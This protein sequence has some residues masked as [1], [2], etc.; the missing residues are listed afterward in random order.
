MQC[1]LGRC[2]YL[3]Q[4]PVHS[5]DR[6][7]TGQVISHLIENVAATSQF[8]TCRKMYLQNGDKCEVGQFI[9]SKDPRRPGQTVVAWM[10]EILQRQG[11]I[12]DFSAMPD[13]IL[14]QLTNVQ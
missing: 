2:M 9:I 11:S 8:K 4:K 13:Y 6:T 3:R 7:V 12:V 14:V 1:H 5:F 10:Q